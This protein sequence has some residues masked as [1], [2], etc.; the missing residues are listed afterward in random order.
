MNA[1]V[2]I[3]GFQNER[4]EFILKEI[5]IITKNQMM[6]LLIKPPYRFYN[7]SRKERLQVCWIEKNRGIY[8]NEGF[9]DYLNCNF[10]INNFLKNKQ[11]FVKGSEKVLWLRN[12][13]D[14]NNIYNLEYKNCPSLPKL[15]EQYKNSPDIVSCMN[16]NKI[17]ALKNVHC[18]N[19]WCIENKIEL[20]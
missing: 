11:V 4:N 15:Y 10:H 19:K 7:L 3:Q 13:L 9:V 6:I 12:I 17:C 2:D 1:I 5:A 14:H 20:K 18:L 16:H 8:W